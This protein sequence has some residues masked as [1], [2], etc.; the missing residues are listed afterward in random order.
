M[1]EPFRTILCP[2]DLSDNSLAALEYAGYCARCHAATLY[3][4]YVLPEVD[5]QLPPALYRLDEKNGDADLAWAEQAA[6]AQLHE[7]AQ[8]RLGSGMHVRIVLR[9]GNP[10]P[11]ILQ[12][13]EHVEATLIVMATHGRAGLT[14]FFVGSVTEKVMRQS[15]CPVLIIRGD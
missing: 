2:V 8:Q 10:V 7:I 6:Q 5:A 9:R 15:L 1:V 4:L 11:V 13:A 12:T 14:H 3:L